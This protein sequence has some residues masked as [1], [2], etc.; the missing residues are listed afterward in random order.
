MPAWICRKRHGVCPAARIGRR[1]LLQGAG[2]PSNRGTTPSAPICRSLRSGHWRS[3]SPQSAQAECSGA[4]LAEPLRRPRQLVRATAACHHLKA[5]LWLPAR[6]HV[7]LGEDPWA[8]VDLECR[9]EL[10]I[11]AVAS[12]IAGE[13]PLLPQRHPNSEAGRT[14][15]RLALVPA[16][17]SRPLH[18]PL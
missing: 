11:E 2:R 12:P 4:A 14:H 9:E 17:H 1:P 3:P 10:G 8:A 15:R 16:Q 7:E 5:G 18:H 13:H 6:G